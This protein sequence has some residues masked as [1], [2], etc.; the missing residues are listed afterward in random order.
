MLKSTALGVIF[1]VVEVISRLEVLD[2]DTQA[3]THTGRRAPNWPQREHGAPY[4]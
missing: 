4:Y 2:Y 3:A 1:A